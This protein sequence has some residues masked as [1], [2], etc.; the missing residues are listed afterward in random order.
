MSPR[1]R[2]AVVPAAFVLAALLVAGCGRAT[3]EDVPTSDVV[4]VTV[5]TVRRGTVQQM[6]D[7][8]GQ[9][10]PQ[11]GAEMDVVPPQPARIESLPVGIG[12]RVRPGDLLVRFDVPSLEAD[13]AAREADVLRAA[14]R[15]TNA[16]AALDRVRGLFDRG[17]AARKEVEDVEREMADAGAAVGEAQGALAA[18]RALNARR[19]VRAR[20]AGVVVSRSHDPGDLVDP[21]TP[22][23]ILRVIDPARLEIVASVPVDALHGL[24]EGAPARVIGPPSYPVEAARLIGRPAAVDPRT[25]TAVVRLSFAGTT[26]LPA[27]TAVRVEIV[28]AAHHDVLVVPAEAIVREDGSTSVFTVGPDGKAHRR[29]VTLGLVGA[30]DAEVVSGVSLGDRVIAEGATGLPDGA[31]VAVRE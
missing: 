24:T 4:P 20:F 31:A 23:P 8:N 15:K 3:D 27:G 12:D 19:T 7:A 29:A 16:S 26:T 1:D 10:A 5:A 30:Q 17:I 2:L 6:V 25:S 18:A 28:A 22:D 21:A 9:V 13:I 11:P 14:A